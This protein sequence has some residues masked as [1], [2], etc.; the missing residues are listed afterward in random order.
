MKQNLEREKSVHYLAVQVVAFGVLFNGLVLIISTLVT[1]LIKHKFRSSEFGVEVYLLIGITLIY[2]ANL[3][4]RRKHTAWIFTLIVYGLYLINSLNRIDSDGRYHYS[5]FNGFKDFILPIIIVLALIFTRKTYTVR[6]DIRSFGV[7]LRIIFIVFIVTFC[8]GVAGFHL[9]DVSDFHH[10]IGLSESIHRTIDQFGLTTNNSLI[11][12]TKRA[13]V[14]L[15]SLNVI[16]LAAVGYALLS[17]FQPLKARFED[18]TDNRERVTGLLSRGHNS[19][20]DFFKIWPKDKFYY[21]NSMKTAGLA[22]GVHRGIALIVGDPFGAVAEFKSLIT[23]FTEYC[24]VNDWQPSFIHTEGHF[25]PL[26]KNLGFMHQKIGEEATVN[27]KHFH[28]T[29]INSKYFRNITSKFKK[30]KYSWEVLKPPHSKA[31]IERLASISNDWLKLPGRNEQTF[32]CGY[33]SEA[34]MQQCDILIIRD[35]ASTI[36]AFINQIPSYDEDEANF[37]LFRQS[38]TALGNSNDYALMNFIEYA[39]SEGFKRVNLGLCPLVGMDKTEVDRSVIDSALSFVYSNGDRFYSFSGLHRFKQKYEPEWS[40]RFIVYRN[41]IR[42]L[43]RTL[44]SLNVA[45][46]PRKFRRR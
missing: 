13:R 18:Q 37:D 45:M 9:M 46:R 25:N 2:L 29:V 11:P 28:E 44:T 35:E 3:L 16:S 14:F 10:Q 5:L 32:M 12:Y 41:G 34:Y 23:D 1:Q 43:T 26:Y 39:H 4:W 7:S 38:S 20:E 6:S 8:Y 40:D 27:T 42:T 31:V 15:D 19:S 24:R 21:F 22:F 17:L 30:Q 33:F 36:Q